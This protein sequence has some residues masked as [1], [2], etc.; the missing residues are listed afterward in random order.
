MTLSVS[1]RRING[2][3]KP[4]PEIY[5]DDEVRATAIA[6]KNKKVKKFAKTNYLEAICEY[7]VNSLETISSSHNPLF[8]DGEN[9]FVFKD[10]G[11]KVTKNLNSH[12]IDLERS[13]TLFVDPV[14]ILLASGLNAE[15]IKE[16]LLNPLGMAITG[17]NAV[18]NNRV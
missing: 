15:A 8:A 12:T 13:I 1:R 7:D 6:D 11:L 9:V 2:V 5:T 16:K 3:E 14:H 4:S 17:K 10:E 18:S